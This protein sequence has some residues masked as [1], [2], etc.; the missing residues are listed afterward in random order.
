L[1]QLYG[2]LSKEKETLEVK[3]EFADVR[4]DADK[5]TFIPTV[6]VN[7]KNQII[8]NDAE[9]LSII[10]YLRALR[11]QN[12]PIL[13]DYESE[14]RLKL[15]IKSK[16]DEQIFILIAKKMLMGYI[17]VKEYI[18]GIIKLFINEGYIQRLPESEQVQLFKILIERGSEKIVLTTIDKNGE[19]YQEKKYM[20]S[21]VFY[22]DYVVFE[23]GHEFTFT[24]HLD[25]TDFKRIPNITGY[26]F[27]G[28][29]K[30]FT[31]T[32]DIPI[33]LST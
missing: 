31:Y 9:I 4:A 29:T 21:R 28:H 3:N 20:D 2:K 27:G 18:N 10:Q 5:D 24:V 12:T 14:E 26:V 17:E 19:T 16:K 32:R 15:D 6:K 22:T 13:L 33:L 11:N 1:D 30:R 25:E 23:D 8:T 7:E